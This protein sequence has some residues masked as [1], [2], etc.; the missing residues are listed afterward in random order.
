M[1]GDEDLVK[2][3]SQGL[4]LEDMRY[5]AFTDTMPPGVEISTPEIQKQTRCRQGGKSAT[6]SYR[7]RELAR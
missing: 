4:S 3:F 2:D 7:S 1:T 5:A 6:L